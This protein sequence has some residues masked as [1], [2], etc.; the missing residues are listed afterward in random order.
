MVVQK[1]FVVKVLSVHFNVDEANV[2]KDF[3]EQYVDRFNQLGPEKI[4]RNKV[5]IWGSSPVFRSME[6]ADE[7]RMECYGGQG[8][9]PDEF[10]DIEIYE[11]GK[12]VKIIRYS[13]YYD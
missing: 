2:N 3:V 8:P 5:T 10:I 12:E 13:R 7:Y 9:S 1:M 6:E 11:I 4:H